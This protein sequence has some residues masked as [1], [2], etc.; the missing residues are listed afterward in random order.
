MVN[1]LLEEMSP[2]SRHLP[3]SNDVVLNLKRT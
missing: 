3:I 2:V 1:L